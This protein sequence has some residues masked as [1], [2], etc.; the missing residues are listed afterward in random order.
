MKDDAA[1]FTF[2]DDSGLMRWRSGDR[3]LV[4][5]K[6]LAEVKAQ[7]ATFIAL[8]RRWVRA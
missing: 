5:F 3:A 6:D 2:D 7:E 1:S 8:V 4:T